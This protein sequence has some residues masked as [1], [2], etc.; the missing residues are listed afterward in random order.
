MTE[1]PTYDVVVLGG[2][3]HGAG[4]VQAAAAGGW[5]ALLVEEKA[6]ASGTSSKS[7]KLIHGGL[8]YLE[9]GQLALVRESLAERET[10][11]RIAPELVKLVPF[12]VPIYRATTRR[13]WKIRAGLSMYA[14]LGNLAKDAWFERVPRREWEALDGLA[15]EGL[16]HVFRYNDGQ[17][18]DAALTRAVVRSA[19]SLGAE[20]LCPAR[21]EAAERDGDGWRVRIVAPDEERI[22]RARALVNAGGP[23][24]NRIRGRITPLPPGFEVDFVAGTHVEL[25]GAMERGI[26]Y[27]EAPRD[28]RAVFTIPWKGRTM[29]GTTEERY[30]GEPRA[31]EPTK[32][33]IE[34]LVETFH[35]YFPRRTVTLV[36]AWAGLRVLPKGPGTAFDRPRETTLV[37]DDE[38]RPTTLAIYGGKLT[39]YRATAE[40][41]LA[42]LA[43][44]LPARER[45]GDTATLRLEADA[46]DRVSPLGDPC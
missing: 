39:G 15:L 38:A 41:V 45:K 16:Q 18:D 28:R 44:S 7:S 14:L 2:G 30:V 20:V 34:Y 4:V 1:L 25:D 6:L 37:V 19:R 22:V 23:W 27:C 21:F 29:V 43:P 3:I 36:D 26:Y 10:L 5:S 17:T 31:V 42:R 8:R 9:S 33:E 46:A 40:K 11:L 32:R 35:R 24:I 13:P 12:Y